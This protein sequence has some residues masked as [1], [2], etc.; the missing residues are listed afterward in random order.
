MMAG[1][2]AIQRLL[3]IMPSVT[4]IETLMPSKN[5]AYRINNLQISAAVKLEKKGMKFWD[6]ID[7]PTDHKKCE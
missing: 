7:S 4:H 3:R 5:K 2:V 6:Q 1:W